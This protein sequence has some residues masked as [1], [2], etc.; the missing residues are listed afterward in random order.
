MKPELFLI[1]EVVL[2]GWYFINRH[3]AKRVRNEHAGEYTMLQ[4][5]RDYMHEGL[6]ANSRAELMH[7]TKAAIESALHC[8]R[9]FFYL[10]H[11]DGTWT[12]GEST[13]QCQAAALLDQVA[14]C[15]Q[16]IIRGVISPEIPPQLAS[17][18]LQFM[19]QQRLSVLIPVTDTM[20]PQWIW[21]S[22]FS[23][24]SPAVE[25]LQAWQMAMQSVSERATLRLASAHLLELEK[26]AESATQVLRVLLPESPAHSLS[27]ME[28]S[29]HL[30]R[31]SDEAPILFAA[32]PHGQDN[33]L[34]VFAEVTAPGLGAVLLASALRGYIDS[35]IAASQTGPLH[36]EEIL[37]K[38]NQYVCRPGHESALSCIVACFD[39]SQKRIEYAAAGSPHW[40]RLQ[41]DGT[42]AS[43]LATGPALGTGEQTDYQPRW[44][45]LEDNDTHFFAVSSLPAQE[46]GQTAQAKMMAPTG[47]IDFQ[48]LSSRAQQLASQW[49][50]QADPGHPSHAVVILRP[51]LP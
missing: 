38:L 43:V 31:K 50:Q 22:Q 37:S 47:S 46:L 19:E 17:A 23:S 15:G 48:E 32:Y 5:L 42:I 40:L 11:R 39:T 18:A 21:A 7:Q 1:P 13:K 45:E 10:P 9:H 44:L 34:V 41:A 14:A 33:L 3:V 29:G 49:D 25:T 2:L 28:W 36:P 4:N 30:Q 8:D 27:G 6:H 35:V 16:P 12:I 26:D 51:R 20:T 24:V